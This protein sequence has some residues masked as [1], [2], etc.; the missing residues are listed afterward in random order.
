MGPVVERPAEPGTSGA[1]ELELLKRRAAERIDEA[2]ERLGALSRAIWSAPELAYEEPE[3]RLHRL[4]CRVGA[5]RGRG[6]A[7]RA[8]AGLPVRVRR[9]ASPGP[10]LRPQPHRRGRGGCGD[11]P[12]GCA[13]EHRCAAAGQGDCPGNPCRRR[14]WWQN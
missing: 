5:A 12:A 2:A 3:V 4:P 1:A 10:R 11:R 7:P 6:G 8:A 9:A 14:W 13:G